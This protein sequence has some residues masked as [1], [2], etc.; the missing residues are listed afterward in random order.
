M[1]ESKESDEN[2]EI[3]EPQE[4]I[5]F[6]S[7]VDKDNLLELKGFLNKMKVVLEKKLEDKL[8]E[9][10]QLKQDLPHLIHLK[11]MSKLQQERDNDSTRNI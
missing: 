3:K 4:E 11:R 7:I 5:K 6:K 9:L 10:T 2:K 1:S 8:D